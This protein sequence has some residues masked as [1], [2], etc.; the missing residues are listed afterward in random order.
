MPHKIQQH[1]QRVD[2]YTQTKTRFQLIDQIKITTSF[3]RVNHK[4]ISNFNETVTNQDFR[5]VTTK[6]I[7][8]KI[9]VSKQG[10]R[11]LQQKEKSTT[12]NHK[13][14]APTRFNKHFHTPLGN[15]NSIS[16]EHRLP[17]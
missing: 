13:T 7:C 17:L 1:K 5:I 16:S 11:F 4:A 10:L 15:P 9:E 8:D 14:K 3:I 2:G 12:E 6:Y